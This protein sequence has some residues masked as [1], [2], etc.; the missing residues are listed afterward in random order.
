ML[1]LEGGELEEHPG[2]LF[3]VTD[4]WVGGGGGEDDADLENGA[5]QGREEELVGA[6]CRGTMHSFGRRHKSAMVT[7]EIAS[8][9]RDINGRPLVSPQLTSRGSRSGIQSSH[10]L[11]QNYI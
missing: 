6:E 5:K 4:E 11:I 9:V 7:L 8:G 2:S 10:P 3:G 1:F